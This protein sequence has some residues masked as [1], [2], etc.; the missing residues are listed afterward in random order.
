MGAGL[1][2][3]DA[4]HADLP[5][6]VDIYNALIPTHTVTWSEELD[7][8]EHKSAWFDAQ[9]RA[10][11]PVLVAEDRGEVVGFTSYEHFRGDGK[12]PGYR[13]TVELSIHVRESHWRRGAGRM[14]I[15]A[16]VE[17]ARSAGLHVLVAAIDAGNEAS[18]RFHERLGFIEVA[19]MPQTG[20]KFGRWLDLVLMQLI[21][22]DRERP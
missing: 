15:D 1:T 19:R 9:G 3:R 2:I 16:L 21:L 13:T 17:R 11:H 12:W 5:V 14:L 7:T 22:D 18:L 10:G 6:I 4:R 20:Q 8:L